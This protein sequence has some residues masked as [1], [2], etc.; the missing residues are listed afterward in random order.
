MRTADSRIIGHLEFAVKTGMVLELAIIMRQ[1]TAKL[2]N[3]CPRCD[4][5]NLNVTAHNG[6]IVWQVLLIYPR[7]VI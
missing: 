1:W 4:H 7:I 6:W 5:P 3:K 2:S